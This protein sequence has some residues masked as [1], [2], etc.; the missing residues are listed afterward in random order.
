MGTRSITV[1]YEQLFADNE[2]HP[3][4]ALYRQFDGYPEGHGH[5][6]VE[7]LKDY[8][9]VNGYGLNDTRT[10]ANGIGNLA[11]QII[12]R[13][14]RGHEEFRMVSGGGM[15]E[16]FI[17]EVYPLT[18]PGTSV[19]GDGEIGVNIYSVFDDQYLAYKCT[20]QSLFEAFSNEEF[21]LKLE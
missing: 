6:L 10:L 9:L 4:A 15:D 17:Y 8:T 21:P 1:F 3:V 20:P 18:P 16:E 19:T 7:Y 14:N 11:V 5:E 13:F 12:A 2:P